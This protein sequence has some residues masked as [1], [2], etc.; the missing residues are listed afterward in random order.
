M[1]CAF[2]GLAYEEEAESKKGFEHVCATCREEVRARFQKLQFSAAEV[3]T[4]CCY[5]NR[6]IRE[7]LQLYEGLEPPVS[8]GICQE[9]EVSL[10]SVSPRGLTLTVERRKFPTRGLARREVE[11]QLRARYGEDVCFEIE[12]LKVG[13]YPGVLWNAVVTILT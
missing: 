11:R 3:R 5:C 2:C 6:V 7:A 9:C 12:D 10:T 8:H 1:A 4:V 13:R